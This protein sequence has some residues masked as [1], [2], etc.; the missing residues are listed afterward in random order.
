MSI[1]Q[2]DMLGGSS[3]SLPI[4]G[5]SYEVQN[6][7]VKMAQA[8]NCPRE[9]VIASAM[10]AAAQAA[11]DRFMWSDGVHE[12]Y[13]QFYTAILGS[14]TEGKSHAISKMFKP[15]AEADSISY[16]QRLEAVAGKS[17]EEKARIPYTTNILQD[18]TIEAYQD[19]L[20]FNSNGVTLVKDEL[21]SF[22]AFKSYNRGKS[23]DEK[24]YLSA[25]ANYAPFKIA[26]KGEGIEVIQRPIVRIIGGIQ[27]EILSRNFGNSEMLDDGML[28]RFLWFAKADDFRKDESGNRVDTTDVESRW[29]QII[30]RIID[31]KQPVKVVFSDNSENLYRGFCTEHIKGYNAGSLFG[32][33]LAVCG[34]LEIYAIMWAMTT[35]ILRYAEL[36]DTEDVLYITEGEMKYTLRCMEYFHQTAMKVYDTITAGSVPKKKDCILGLKDYII[37]QSQFAESIGVSQ[38]Y[39]SKVINK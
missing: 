34:K 11:G 19:A 24:I 7:I 27:P 3:L 16:E 33:E 36:G 35:A 32:Y 4:D 5:L 22:F 17:K 28:P 39:V 26:R 31:R 12:D 20:K 2:Q 23:N 37:N 18:A 6:I 29:R 38:Q 25:F 15:L 21:L 14:S 8:L 10:Q 30:W 13:P 9:F 1:L